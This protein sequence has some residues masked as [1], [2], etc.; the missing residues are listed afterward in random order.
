M[1]DHDKGAIDADMDFAEHEKTFARFTAMVKWGCIG[2]ATLLV[3]MAL[4]LVR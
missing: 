3:L 4:F 1:A 2:L